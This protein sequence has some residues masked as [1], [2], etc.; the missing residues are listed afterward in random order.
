MAVAR[1]KIVLDMTLRE[2]AQQVNEHTESEAYD[3]CFRDLD[4][5]PM[6]DEQILA[7]ARRIEHETGEQI[8]FEEPVD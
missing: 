2:L 6:S 1:E 3:E 7:L 8:V 4:G 5:Q